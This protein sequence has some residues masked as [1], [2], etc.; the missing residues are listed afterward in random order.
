ML[1]LRNK[2][3]MSNKILMGKKQETYLKGLKQDLNSKGCL[4]LVNLKSRL[5]RCLLSPKL[6]YRVNVF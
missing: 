3:G 1:L 4:M 5:Q 6:I 2:A